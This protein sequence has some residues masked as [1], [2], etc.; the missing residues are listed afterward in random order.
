MER[1]LVGVHILVYV[2]NEDILNVT[3]TNKYLGD[4]VQEERNIK[5]RYICSSARHVQRC[6]NVLGRGQI[7][8]IEPEQYADMEV[9]DDRYKIGKQVRIIDDPE[10]EGN[11]ITKRYSDTV[12]RC[13]RE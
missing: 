13:K 12:V 9:A 3:F 2:H 4:K 10:Y 11:R 5:E 1:N 8:M 6:V 7:D